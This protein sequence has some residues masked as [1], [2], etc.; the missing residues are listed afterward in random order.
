MKE[1][2]IKILKYMTDAYKNQGQNVFIYVDAPYSHSGKRKTKGDLYRLD[3]D[4][5][6]AN[7]T[8]MEN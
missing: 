3:I 2:A 4:K 1:D 7:T 6:G 8:N 5:Y